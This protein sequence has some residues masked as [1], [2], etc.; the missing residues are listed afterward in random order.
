MNLPFRWMLT[1]TLLLL[2]ACSDSP[3]PSHSAATPRT[4]AAHAEVAQN[5]DL[6]N[7]EG[8]AQARRGLIATPQGQVR[9]AEGEVIWDFD[10]FAFVQGEAPTTVNPSLWRQALLNNQVGL[11]KVSDKIY[12][13]RGFDLANMTLIEGASGWIVIDPL[14]SQETA[15]F[16]MDFVAQHLGARPVSTMIFSHSPCR[17]L[18]RRPRRNQRRRRQGSSGAG[19]RPGWVYG[20]KP[21]AKT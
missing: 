8:L 1:S 13:L 2:S 15:A 9:D 4:Q 16:A 19:D 10:S 17:S 12:Q 20:R 14:T 11:F 7:V 3:A 21:P 5:Y 18:W 6:S